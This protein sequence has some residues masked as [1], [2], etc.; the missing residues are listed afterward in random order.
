[1]TWPS[2]MLT[3][4]LRASASRLRRVR[5]ADTT[6]VLMEACPIQSST[7]C[8]AAASATGVISV[9]LGAPSWR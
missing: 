7:G 4:T 3:Q 1:M 8:L 5:G 6:V 9:A 2:P